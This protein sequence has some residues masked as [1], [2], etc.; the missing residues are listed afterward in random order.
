[1]GQSAQSLRFISSTTVNTNISQLIP[2]DTLTAPQDQGLCIFWAGTGIYTGFPV[3]VGLQSLGTF[4]FA[5]ADIQIASG[6]FGI[7]PYNGQM[8][9]QGLTGVVNVIA[10]PTSG[11]GTPLTGILTVFGITGPPVVIPYQKRDYI[12]QGTTTGNKTVNA[13][14]TATVLAP[15]LDGT[16][17]RIKALGW[18]LNVAPAAAT[19]LI[20]Q[21]SLSGAVILGTS[22]P[23]AASQMNVITLDIE[24][25]SGIAANNQT[26]LNIPCSI[27]FETWLS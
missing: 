2:I 5:Y 10:F 8:V 22:V 15:P 1:M 20:W 14:T 27:L 18:S 12:G 16:Y 17:Y 21:D 26:S 23:V 7:F 19:K 25:N 6:N 9:T 13:G 24:W 4:N 11:I 3:T